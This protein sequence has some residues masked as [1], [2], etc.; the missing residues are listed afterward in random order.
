MNDPVPIR[1]GSPAAET[2]RR[3]REELS[4]SDTAC[5]TQVLEIVQEMSQ[6]ADRLSVQELADLIGRDLTTVTKIM[7]AATCLGYN[8]AAV[9]VTTLAEAIA[10]I[11]YEKIR[12]LVLSLMLMETAEACNASKHSQDVAAL[13]L[14]SGLTAQA[15]IAQFTSM[16]A[17]QAFICAALRPYG[18]LLLSSFLPEAY[19][20]ALVLAGNGPFDLACRDVTGLT[21]LELGRAILTEAQLPKTITSTLQPSPPSVVKSTGLTEAERL[22]VV[23]EFAANVCE[24]I[25]AP[26]TTAKDCEAGLAQLLKTYVRSLALTEKDLH[27]TLQDVSTM[28]GTFGRAQ[29]L[30]GFSSL[31]ISRLRALGEGTPWTPA[32]ASR[33]PSRSG[34]SDSARPQEADLLGRG[35]AEIK[36]LLEVAPRDAPRI[37]GVAA[38]AVRVA[39][40]LRSCL[41]FLP[42]RASQLF[43]AEI[44]SGGLFEE[45]RHQPVLDP[46]R[47]DVFTVCLERGEDAVIQD[48]ADPKIAPFIPD[49]FKR[50]AEAGP[51][52]LLPVQDRA[53]TFA[54]I[55]GVV[56]PGE[57]IALTA[58]RLQQLKALRLCLTQLRP[59]AEAADRAAA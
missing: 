30:E 51:F 20:E 4:R 33:H 3:V 15:I 26:E 43:V 36:R 41:V 7:K 39:L 25:A 57:S 18:R 29:G 5:V 21:P 42:E 34:A 32:P 31:G 40:H 59:G 1:D 45:I 23:S 19:E 11:G 38:R 6:R 49:W 22:L 54:I 48:P 13:A 12:N 53:G 8:P 9:E 28:I 50:A 58:P 46:R 37:F 44:G 47:R 24:L 35:L 52:V 16:N 17:E 55:C 2:L 56:A 14:T 27:G 10:V